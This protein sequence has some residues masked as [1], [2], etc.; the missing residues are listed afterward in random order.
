MTR[1]FVK[2]PASNIEMEIVAPAKPIL[3]GEILELHYENKFGKRS[4]LTLIVNSVTTDPKKNEVILY[5]TESRVVAVKENK[6]IKME[7]YLHKPGTIAQRPREV[8]L[9]YP[10]GQSVI[11]DHVKKVEWN[12][13]TKVAVIE[14]LQ[15]VSSTHHGFGPLEMSY[16]TVTVT[17]E[18]VELIEVHG[19]E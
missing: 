5:A 14:I 11:H 17:L 7:V 13:I 12:E 10:G 18:N 15:Q 3:V 1:V 19:D 9:H 8:V 16:D 4:P 2:A 6:T